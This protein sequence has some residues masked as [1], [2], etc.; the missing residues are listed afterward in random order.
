MHHFYSHDITDSI[1]TLNEEE[2]RHS[3]KVMR[4]SV[5]DEIMVFDGLG[6]ALRCAI[7][8]SGK[9]VT[10]NV[11]TVE[12][13]E[14]IPAFSLTLAISPTKSA[15]RMEW[16]MEKLVEIGVTRVVFIKTEKG[17]RSRIN[18]KRILKKAVSALKQSGNLWLPVVEAEVKFNDFIEREKTKHKFIAHCFDKEKY[19]INGGWQGEAV[20]V[21][22]GPEGDFSETE[23]NAASALGFAPISLGLPRYRTETA[24]VVAGT[25]F[26]HFNVTLL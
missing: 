6:K 8:S 21:C 23:V 9:I 3:I 7:A 13:E 5:G 16:M 24:A 14:T 19:Q 11:L 26:N 4:L 20:C 12:R 1:V 17:E 15:D 2:S 22:I 10:A 25:L 18:E